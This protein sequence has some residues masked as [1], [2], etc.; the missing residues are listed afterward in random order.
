VKKTCAYGGARSGISARHGRGRC[1][2]GT[3]T[4]QLPLKG[5]L[6]TAQR[7]GEG[8]RHD[9][10]RQ[11]TTCREK[12]NSTRTKKEYEEKEEKGERRKKVKR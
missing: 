8:P 2:L 7:P 12:Q 5:I 1:G 4:V 11:Y 9:A 10:V 3:E 6:L